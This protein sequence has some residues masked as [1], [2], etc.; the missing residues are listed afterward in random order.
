LPARPFGC[1]GKIDGIGTTKASVDA[2]RISGCMS[3]RS[4]SCGADGKGVP[5]TL[6]QDNKWQYKNVALLDFETGDNGCSN[7]TPDTRDIVKGTAPAGS[8]RGLRFKIGVPFE[9]N[10]QDPTLAPS[11]LNLTSMFWTWQGGY[12][13]IKIDMATGAAS[14]SK[15]A[16][17]HDGAMKGKMGGKPDAPPRA[18]PCILGS[19]MCQSAS[20]T[21]APTA[22]ANGNRIDVAF[23]GFDPAKNVVVFDPAPVLATTNVEK[24]IRP[25]HRRGACRSPTIPSATP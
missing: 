18:F 17:G 13:F 14:M 22:C 5:L 20:R 2:E 11:P 24:S 1:A 6:E 12:K 15:D 21:T 9:L 25:R 19:T 8:Y 7:G 23:D 3:R 4:N 16:G 10:H